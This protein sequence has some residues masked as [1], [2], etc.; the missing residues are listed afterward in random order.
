MLQDR[1]D[2]QAV[3]VLPDQL[4]HQ[5]PLEQ[6]VSLVRLEVLDQL[7]QQGHLDQWV[8]PDLLEKPAQPDL[9]DLREL[10]VIKDQQEPLV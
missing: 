3:L 4:A 5:D 10:P 6:Q 9:L 1:Q 7:D 8:Q 2:Q